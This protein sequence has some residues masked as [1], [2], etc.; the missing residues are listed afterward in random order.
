MKRTLLVLSLPILLLLL[1][2]VALAQA[3][4]P[5]PSWDP[6]TWFASTA[7][8][9]GVIVALVSFLKRNLVPSLSGW[10]TIAASFAVGVVGAVI[11]SMTSLYDA[12]LLDAASF[13]VGASILASGGWDAI[14]GLLG[15]N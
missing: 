1:V 15:K 6:T 11:A 12:S 13:G 10:M 2:G 5:E 14:R 9:A 3:T 8:W 4:V 7:A